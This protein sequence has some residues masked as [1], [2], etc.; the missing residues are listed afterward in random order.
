MDFYCDHSRESDYDDDKLLLDDENINQNDRCVQ[1]PKK[2]HS[3]NSLIKPILNITNHPTVVVNELNN[4]IQSSTFLNDDYDD[5]FH[6]H[7]DVL[8]AQ[9]QKAW[10]KLVSV[11]TLC[12]CFMVAELIGGYL[13]GSLSVM[14][15]AAHLFSDLIGFFVSLLSI[16]ISKKSPTRTMT[17]GYYRA[18]VLGAFLSVLAVWLLAGIFCVIAIGRLLKQEY[19]IDANT[20]LIVASI[21]VIVN[22]LMGAVLHD[23]CHSHSHGTGPIHHNENINVRA[24][25][26]HVIGD[27]LQSIGVLIAA[28]II[29]IFP[30]AEV[31]DP[32]CTLLFSIIVVYA[33][34]RVA[35][36]TI[37]ILLEASP[38]LKIDL[39][40][41]LG[42]IQGVR[43]VH[44]IHVWSLSPGKEAIAVH[45]AV[46]QYC[47]RNLVL[48]NATGIIKSHLNAVSSTIQIEKY[49]EEL[50]RVC[51]QC[52]ILS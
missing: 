21:G 12:L 33:T 13:A 16:W 20:M 51:T 43:H 32:I 38:K 8:V 34:L 46:D 1:C 29:K 17:F 48:K 37:K 50:M 28:I 44:G 30:N 23:I 10:K 47:D 18:E 15:D 14:T 2:S 19:H 36:D 7:I 40:S 42:N 25:A 41:L 31:A 39:K 24:A 45:L 4:C 27:L 5:D 3:K 6:C 52:Q 35:Y 26:A 11:S 22:I 9:D 49:N